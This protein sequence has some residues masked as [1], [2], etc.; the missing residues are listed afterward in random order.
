MIIREVEK[1]QE[2]EIKSSKEEKGNNESTL[3]TLKV[4][5]LF[6]M[7]MAL[8]V[9]KAPLKDSRMNKS[10]IQGIQS[11]ARCVA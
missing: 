4:G 1:I 5:E 11:K 7:K 3:P 9:I 6:L 8:Q 2:I 10:F